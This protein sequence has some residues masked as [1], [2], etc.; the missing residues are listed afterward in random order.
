M[1]HLRLI[2]DGI[3][4]LPLNMQL[5]RHPELW[6][7]HQERRIAPGS[8]HAEM[9][10]IWVRYNES[11][12]YRARGDFTGFNDLHIPVWYPAW[13]KLPALRPIVFGLAARL[14][15]VMIGGIL[16]TKIPRG[17]AIAPH[18]D[19]GWHP[20]YFNTKVYVVLQS[21]PHCSNRVEDESVVMKPG[22]AWYF[23]NTK[24]HEV[25]NLGADDRITLIVCLRCE[26]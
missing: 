16:I 14:E 20:E 25:N 19:A 24:E 26:E 13:H 18:A 6:D 1:K 12:P 10:D 4:V 8:P 23:D 9:S 3:D 15:A 2:A 22:E 17:G 21:N 11:E 5:Q 7:V